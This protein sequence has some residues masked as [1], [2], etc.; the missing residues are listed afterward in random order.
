MDL[1]LLWFGFLW[2]LLGKKGGAK[3]TAPAPAPAGPAVG[4]AP[5]WPAVL[6]PGLPPFP[7]GWEYDEP[8]PRPVVARARQLLSELWARG[9]GA[10]KTE[11]T[12]GRWIV[13]RSEIT[14]GNKR[15]VVAYR[16]RNARVPA[17]PELPNAAAPLGA[18]VVPVSLQP[19]G[20]APAVAVPVGTVVMV[21]GH[22]YRCRV[23]I[24]SSQ[25]PLTADMLDD[26]RR[27][28]EL[29]GGSAVVVRR[30]PPIEAEYTMQ[31]EREV[32]LRTGAPL[33][34]QWGPMTAT[35]QLVGAVDITPGASPGASPV[36]LP[37]LRRGAGISPQAPSKDVAM[38]QSRLGIPADGRFGAGTEAAVKAF[39]ARRSL[40]ADGIVGPNTWT[41][42]FSSARA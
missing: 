23:Q 16:E 22:V 24:L 34:L 40:S 17:P 15:G 11:K 2:A 42:L 41:A 10:T 35:V 13:Y 38:L 4:P 33:T 30:G 8:P 28:V 27:G 29:G 6:P 32:T 31:P 19:G 1:A 39:Q 21:P 12:A 36:G 26:V 18:P 5:P 3:S 7:G 25:P 37:L 9:S 20:T 14:R